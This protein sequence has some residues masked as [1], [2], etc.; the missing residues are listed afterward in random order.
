[1]ENRFEQE[2]NMIFWVLCFMALKVTSLN[3]K[4]E[5]YNGFCLD[6]VQQW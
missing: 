6:G 3:E 1:M 2:K 5:N 4:F